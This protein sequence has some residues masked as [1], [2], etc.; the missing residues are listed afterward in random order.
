MPFL[1]SIRIMEDLYPD[2]SRNPYQLLVTEIRFIR[3][4]KM[5]WFYSFLQSQTGWD[6]TEYKR[7]S[8]RRSLPHLFL[9]VGYNTVQLY[10]QGTHIL[11]A[12]INCC[13]KRLG[14]KIILCYCYC[15]SLYIAEPT[16][17]TGRVL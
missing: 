14:C 15:N 7:G 13:C 12:H 10:V 8:E 5:S 17:R 11:G 1:I 4:R 9:P 6:F 3:Q 2:Y 16:P